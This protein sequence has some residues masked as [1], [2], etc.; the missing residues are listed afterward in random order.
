MTQHY[1][2]LRI[3]FVLA[4]AIALLSILTQL[5]PDDGQIAATE[6]AAIPITAETADRLKP[7][8]DEVDPLLMVPG[9]AQRL[10]T[11]IVI[12]GQID[13][14]DAT[15]FRNAQMFVRLR[16]LTG[17]PRDAVCLRED[18]SLWA[19]G[20]QARVALVN[21]LRSEQARCLPALD[22]PGENDS[23]QC[24]VGGQDLSRMMIR[25][26]WARPKSLH[27]SAYAI[28]LDIAISAKA[29]LW[30]GTWP[31]NEVTQRP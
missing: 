14:L 22:A 16:H 6:T 20:L 13:A 17:P 10:A 9:L 12:E 28:E 19:C 4:A 5:T 15:T 23:F 30:R 7:A 27:A 26:G 3:A 24:W 21:T 1:L 8:Q 11:P 18:G 25:A 29:G 2:T 31:A